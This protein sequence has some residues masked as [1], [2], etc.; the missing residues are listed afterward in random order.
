MI[1]KIVM[2]VFGF[3]L[4]VACQPQIQQSE[5]E[6]L[7]RDFVSSIKNGDVDEIKNYSNVPLEISKP[8]TEIDSRLFFQTIFASAEVKL[9][10][11][12]KK[13]ILKIDAYPVSKLIESAKLQID[14]LNGE[15]ISKKEISKEEAKKRFIENIQ[16]TKKE[17]KKNHFSFEV[18]FEKKDGKLYFDFNDDETAK[19]LEPFF[20]S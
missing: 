2:I 8:K 13:D 9:E 1:K 17:L 20:K 3:I 14:T 18:K 4:L 15:K 6:A 11:V 10:V 5:K 12:D 19:I 7:V 16:K